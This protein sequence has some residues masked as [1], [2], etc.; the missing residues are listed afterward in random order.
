[1][2][3]KGVHQLPLVRATVGE[4]LEL[5]GLALQHT[6]RHKPGMSA[7]CH[8]AVAVAGAKPHTSCCDLQHTVLH[9][10]VHDTFPA[11]PLQAS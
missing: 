6:M 9:G 1:V 8:T 10:G 2:V 4:V 3:C 5:P 7:L 11:Q